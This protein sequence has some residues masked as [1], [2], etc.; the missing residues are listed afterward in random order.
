VSPAA[1]RQ[2]A[3]HHP[4]EPH[5][6]LRHEGRQAGRLRGERQRHVQRAAQ[7]RDDRH[8]AA[9]LHGAYGALQGGAQR[10][11]GQHVEG[12]VEEA[13][14][15]DGRRDEAPHLA[16][17]QRGGR[18]AHRPQVVPSGEQAHG[19]EG[20]ARR[21]HRPARRRAVS[22]AAAVTEAQPNGAAENPSPRTSW[23]LACRSTTL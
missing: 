14:V 17:E 2:Q 8:Q 3:K 15:E 13:G 10:H 1:R 9:Q 22:A 21:H 5:R 12:D 20:G 11:K 19:V 23:R 7:Q 18:Q 4:R 6:A 16:R